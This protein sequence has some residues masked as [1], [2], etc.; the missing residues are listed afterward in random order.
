ML[1]EKNVYIS[2]LESSKLENP[3]VMGLLKLPFNKLC[4]PRRGCC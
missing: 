2:N 1:V 4:I 3:T